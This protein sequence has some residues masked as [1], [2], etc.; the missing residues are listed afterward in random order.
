MRG[1]ARVGIL[2]LVWGMMAVVLMW[3]VDD[4]GLIDLAAEKEALSPLLLTVSGVGAV[5]LVGR[6]L[7]WWVTAGRYRR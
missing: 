4:L 5:L 3:S 7:H 6:G 2:L 1:V